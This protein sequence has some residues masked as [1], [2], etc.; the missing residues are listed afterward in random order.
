MTGFRRA[1]L[2][3]G[4]LVLSPALW[5]ASAPAQPDVLRPRKDIDEV[6]RDRIP[7][8]GGVRR[9]LLAGRADAKVDV[10]RLSVRLPPV[11]G[12]VLCV[13]IDARDGRYHAAVEYDLGSRPA[14]RYRLALPTAHATELARYRSRELAVLAFLG[15]ACQ[16]S[17]I[18]LIVPAAWGGDEEAESGLLLLVSSLGA[19]LRVYHTAE[20]RY[21]TCASVDGTA[22][23]AECVVKLPPGAGRVDLLLLRQNA[24][25]RQR[26]VALPLYVP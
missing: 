16:E 25:N 23:D 17:R 22:Y 19:D 21:F 13:T 14:G 5:P 8:S 9:G 12:R 3:L 1:A 6:L 11:D 4:I 18:E 10:E 2:A 7:V 24:E 26:P 20:K 15:G